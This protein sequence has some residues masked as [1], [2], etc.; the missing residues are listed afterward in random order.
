MQYIRRA[1]HTIKR[2]KKNKPEHFEGRVVQ[3]EKNSSAAYYPVSFDA[4]CREQAC[5]MSK[6]WLRPW[7]VSSSL[8][9][10]DAPVVC[11]YDKV[12]HITVFG[13]KLIAYLAL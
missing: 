6:S 5:N 10:F 4:T 7:F 1:T 2:N 8:L 12:K 3:P 9:I 11:K 13:I